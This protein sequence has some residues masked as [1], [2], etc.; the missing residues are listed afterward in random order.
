MEVT[1][2]PYPPRALSSSTVQGAFV[3]LFIHCRWALRCSWDPGDDP[4]DTDVTP[5]VPLMGQCDPSLWEGRDATCEPGECCDPTGI[6]TC[7]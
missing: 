3:C 6:S 1:V 5:D 4:E 7:A 2:V